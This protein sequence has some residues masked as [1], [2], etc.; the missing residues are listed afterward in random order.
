MKAEVQWSRQVAQFVGALAPDPRKKLRAGLHGL[1]SDRGNIKDLVDELI[2]YKRLRV[3]PY[4]VI[5]RE[6]LERG[7]PVRKCLFVEHRNVVYELFT[8]MLLDD[9]H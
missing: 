4:R 5:Y 2:G 8:Q 7:R 3:G 6:T 1:V 9:L